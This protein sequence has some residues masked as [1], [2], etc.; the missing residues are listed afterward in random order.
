MDLMEE[1]LPKLTNFILPGGSELSANI[2][3]ARTIVRRVERQFIMKEKVYKNISVNIYLN[4][5]SDY[6]FVLARFVNNQKG[7]KD[8]IWNRSH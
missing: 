8:T 3:I 1:K 4:R 2:H 7:I 5:L 6:L